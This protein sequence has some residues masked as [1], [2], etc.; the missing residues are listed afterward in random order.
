VLWTGRVSLRVSTEA[1]LLPQG[2]LL[3]LGLGREGQDR[4]A[5]SD[6]A[7]KPP[8]T[9]LFAIAATTDSYRVEMA[10]E[11]LLVLAGNQEVCVVCDA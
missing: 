10:F 7:P 8:L 2:A 11:T 4:S 9:A 5:A 1:A 3:I 6:T